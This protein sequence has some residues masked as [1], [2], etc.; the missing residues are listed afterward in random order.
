[1]YKKYYFLLRRLEREPLK[2]VKEE[3]WPLEWFDLVR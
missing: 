3:G 1:M 2:Q